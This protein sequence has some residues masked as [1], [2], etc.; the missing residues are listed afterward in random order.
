MDEK[1][2][3]I[4]CKS[5]FSAYESMTTDFSFMKKKFIFTQYCHQFHYY[6]M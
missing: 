2:K 5:V 3:I 6:N 4:I 1:K